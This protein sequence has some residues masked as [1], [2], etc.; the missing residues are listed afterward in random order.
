[1]HSAILLLITF[2]ALAQFAAYYGR[3]ALVLAAAR[4]IPA[5]VLDAAG[6]Q[7]RSVSRHDFEYL[8]ALCRLTPNLG[9]SCTSLYLVSLY[10]HFLTWLALLTGSQFPRITALTRHERTLCARYAAIQLDL[11]LQANHAFTSSISSY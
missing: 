5:Q 11:R 8:M 4:E 6:I 10:F 7:S 3:A 2:V 9:P 1:M